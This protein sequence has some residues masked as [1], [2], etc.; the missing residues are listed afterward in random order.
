MLGVRLARRFYMFLRQT[1]TGKRCRYTKH[2][3]KDAAL[4][5]RFQRVNCEETAEKIWLIRNHGKE[6]VWKQ[7][8]FISSWILI[9][10]FLIHKYIVKQ[11]SIHKILVIIFLELKSTSDWITDCCLVD[12]KLRF[13]KPWRFWTDWDPPTR[14]CWW[15]RPKPENNPKWNESG[16]KVHHHVT[17]FLMFLVH[18]WLRLI[19]YRKTSHDTKW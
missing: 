9:D 11:L 18:C 13:L 16:S 17:M 8:R 3:E 14:H 4:E 12:R 7:Q 19:V 6:A 2:I 1:K 10:K 5:R 15:R